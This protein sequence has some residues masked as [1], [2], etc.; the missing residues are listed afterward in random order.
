LVNPFVFSVTLLVEKSNT[1]NTNTV[2]IYPEVIFTD[3]KACFA[4][5]KTHF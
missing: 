3:L 5:W 4:E 1:D 2:F